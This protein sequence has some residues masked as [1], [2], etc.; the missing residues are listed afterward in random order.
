M[1]VVYRADEESLVRIEWLATS[2][3]IAVLLYVV[4]G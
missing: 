3:C 4:I 1:P 2:P